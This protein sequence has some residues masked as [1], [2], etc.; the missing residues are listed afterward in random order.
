M[1]ET[2]YSRYKLPFLVIGIA[3]LIWTIAG[4]FEIKK[5]P[6]EGYAA[7]GDR[8][9]NQVDPGGP[10]E[11]AGI[12]AGDRITKIDGISVDN[13]A[14][15]MRRGRPAIGSEGSATIER[16]G[17]EKTL[18][19]T[20]TEQP[21]RDMVANSLGGLVI[22]LAFLFAGL[23]VHRRNPTQLSEM[24]CWLSLMMALL[25]VPAPYF[26][27]PD[28]RR[29]VYAFTSLV[30]GFAVATLLYFCVSF[31]SPKKWLQSQSWM[32]NAILVIAPLVGLCFAL[33]GLTAPDLNTSRSQMLS[34][35][36]AVVFGGYF[37]LAVVAVIHSYL[38]ASPE[39]RSANGLNLVLLGILIGAGPII[40]SVVYHTLFPHAGDL[41]TERLWTVTFI[42]VPIGLSLALMKLEPVAAK[43]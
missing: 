22:G 23:L 8:V 30:A 9:V 28:A 6:Y 20:Y 42:A 2:N 17:V 14:A 24:F 4:V 13:T 18:T 40:V 10:A 37:L 15:L 33:L 7:G 38:A 32:R 1:A 5:I 19:F 21:L 43:E 39:A 16:D 3:L 25:F 34:L 29:V 12:M 31:P 11:K 36:S 27:S 41:P 26:A 35:V